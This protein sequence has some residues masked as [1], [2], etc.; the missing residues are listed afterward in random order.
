[1]LAGVCLSAVH[2]LQ[3]R[4][5]P[6]SGRRQAVDGQVLVRVSQMASGELTR[7]ACWTVM[8]AVGEAYKD[9]RQQ[10]V[11]C[12]FFWSVGMGRE[13]LTCKRNYKRK[14]GG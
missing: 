8:I 14:R 4:G 10:A 2:Y 5:Q 7:C 6:E 11:A 3:S 9:L 12:V 1:M 13:K